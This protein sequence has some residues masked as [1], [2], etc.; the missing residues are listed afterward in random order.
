MD[1]DDAA[2]LGLSELRAALAS[3]DPGVRARA[4]LRVRP[5]PGVQEALIEA[6]RDVSSE[7]RLAAVRALGRLQT[8]RAT[9]ALIQVSTGELSVSVRA[10]AVA[11]LGR[12]LEARTRDEG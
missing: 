1:H 9:Q 2:S 10:E 12:I 6:L 5:E 11:A 8:P 7:V 3:P 4:I